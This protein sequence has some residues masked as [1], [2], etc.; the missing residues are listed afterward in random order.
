MKKNN[1]GNLLSWL[2]QFLDKRFI[3]L[4]DGRSLYQYQCTYEEYCQLQE[5]LR[6]ELNLSNKIQAACFTLFCSEWYRREYH[7]SIGWSWDGIRDSLSIALSPQDI[8]H[9]IEKGLVDYWGRDLHYYSDN[10]RNFLG[11]VFAE[12][13]LPV[14][15]LQED[16][17]KF[18]SFI[19]FLLRIKDSAELQGWSLHA[20][21]EEQSERFYLPQVFTEFV[22]IEL[23]VNMVEQLGSLVKHYNLGDEDNPGETLN[24][25]Y[26]GWRQ[27][28][29]LPLES[30]IAINLLNSLLQTASQEQRTTIRNKDE[31]SCEHYLEENGAIKSHLFLPSSLTFTLN[32]LPN[33]HVFKLYVYE[34]GE[35]VA[36]LAP[37][38]PAFQG[39]KATLKVKQ[40]EIIFKRKSP[41]ASLYL[42]AISAGVEVGGIKVAESALDVSISPIGFESID[43]RWVFCGQGTFSTKSQF[44]LL[45]LPKNI[46]TDIGEDVTLTVKEQQSTVEG[47]DVVTVE[48]VGT[49][50]ISAAEELGDK[51]KITLGEN[52]NRS[53]GIE[54]I[55]SLVEWPT[56]PT[57]TYV[58]LPKA[59]LSYA[60]GIGAQ[61]E[62][63]LYVNGKKLSET[64]VADCLG[65]RNIAVKNRDGITLLRRRV[66]VLP[67]DFEIELLAHESVQQGSLIIKTKA[68]CLFEITNENVLFKKTNIDGGYNV[69]L[70]VEGTPPT[71]LSLRVYP[72]LSSDPITIFLPYPSI[73]HLL[74]DDD[75]QIITDK[76]L[77]VD[78]LLGVRAILFGRHN[79]NTVFKIEMTLSGSRA[80][81]AYYAWQYKV[82][83]KPV[84]VSLYSLRQEILNLLS[85]DEGI[86]AFVNL[87]ISSPEFIRR[88][89]IHRYSSF[90]DLNDDSW[91]ISIKT[92]SEG[93][94]SPELILLH[95]PLR[96][97]VKLT[98]RLSEGV[99]TGLYG[100]PTL[101]EKDGPWLVVPSKQSDSFFR[102]Y[103]IKGKG[104][105]FGDVEAYS[106]KTLQK[107]VQLFN[108]EDE[109]NPIVLVLDQM[110]ESP[111]HSGWQFLK[112][113]FENYKHLP[114]AV[115]ETWRALLRHPKALCMSFFI[116]NMDLEYLEKV[117]VEVPVLWEMYPFKELKACYTKYSEYLV[118]NGELKEHV[119]S[120]MQL[121]FESFEMVFSSF[122]ESLQKYI[123]NDNHAE[124]LT[125]DLLERLIKIWMQELIQTNAESNWPEL[126]TGAL[127][128]WCRKNVKAVNLDALLYGARYQRDV[129]VFPIF[130]AYVSTGLAEI[131]DVFTGTKDELFLM[132][133]MREFHPDWFNSMF[134]LVLSNNL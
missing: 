4:P 10:R 127:E 120:R 106:I 53:V 52:S 26:P 86:D 110:A 103:F 24:A 44:I 89:R 125:T 19:E 122:N 112:A 95:D 30:E 27:N 33:S 51:Y 67:S 115:F 5:L 76:N 11:S 97:P 13:G 119:E 59:E 81:R 128:E 96:T 82:G 126:G 9:L 63:S 121:W 25:K 117:Y 39:L 109:L 88:Y 91:Q 77:C 34:D 129:K 73:G 123:C 1:Y 36:E 48:G 61:S 100:L 15:A 70:E 20:L 99:S 31:L 74:V 69:A 35:P 18:K 58:G 42:V 29:P 54:L 60:S 57:T 80:R 111:N 130:A 131:S 62:S 71:M 14:K 72:S 64:R 28:F 56:V 21:A 90:I 47:A 87:E 92:T 32:E 8:S 46:Q 55:G 40:R 93:L 113:L 83:N 66:G 79:R 108:H 38:F 43:D 104:Q 22:T 23:I 37:A 133:R 45:L 107:A 124:Q 132:H 49:L 6:S 84:E 2:N 50:F 65:R 78:Q 3:R 101:V 105:F 75:E 118:G 85:L 114:L 16:G 98:Q 134:G 94:P 116:F 68:N 12:G 41:A 17:N 102:P 7:S